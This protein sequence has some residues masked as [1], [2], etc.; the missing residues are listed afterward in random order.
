[1]TLQITYPEIVGLSESSLSVAFCVNDATGP[2]DAEA[3]VFLNGE[4]RAHSASA[5]ATRLLK[6]VDLAPDTEYRIEIRSG[7]ASGQ[8]DDYF[9]KSIRTHPAPEASCVGSFGTLNDLHF[10]EARI[11]GRMTEDME[12][13]DEAEGFPL[14]RASDTETPYTRFM[15]EDAVSAINAAGVDMAIIKGDIADRGLPEQFAEAR[16]VFGGFEMPHHAFLGNHDYLEHAKGNKVDGYALLGQPPAPRV[17]EL[18]GWRLVLLETNDPGRHPGHF[19]EGRMRWLEDC[20][21]ESEERET[22]TLLLMHHHPVPPEH[23][24]SYPNTIGLNPEH[25]VELFSLLG[26]STQTKGVLIGHTHRNRVRRYA[27]SGNIPYAEVNNSKDYPGGWGHYRLFED[28]S[29]RQEVRRTGSERALAHSTKCRDLFK[30]YYRQFAFGALA[31]R[32]FV[33]GGIQ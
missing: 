8:P 31:D 5:A 14:V 17:V 25:S 23:A 33:A 22:P 24:T 27:A 29:F 9:P 32:S 12:Y 10:G 28:G 7:S 20:L 4:V 26:R 30:G 18:G 19:D 3:Q 16:A 15:N 6:I 13:G 2:V 21:R 1:M 11:G